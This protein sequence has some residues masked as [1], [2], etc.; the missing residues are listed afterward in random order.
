MISAIGEIK[1]VD[2]FIEDFPI[3]LKVTFFPNKFMEEKL[4]SV[5]GKSKISWLKN[6]AKNVGIK[7]NTNMSLAQQVYILKEKLYENGNT[8]VLEELKSA[9]RE[10]IRQSQENPVELMKWLYE[11]QGEMRFGAENRLYLILANTDSLED[12]WKLKRAIDQLEPIINDY[13]KSFSQDT[14]T[15]I[16]FC[17]KKQ[18]YQALSDVIFLIR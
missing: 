5:L 6:K 7:I 11:N 4:K 12:S 16:N 9:E 17:Y 13:L 3:D 14:L 18:N 10:V 15:K 8:D 1:S 2:F